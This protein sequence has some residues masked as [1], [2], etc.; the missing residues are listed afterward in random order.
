MT[1]SYLVAFVS[2]VLAL[3]DVSLLL[4][5]HVFDDWYYAHT[6]ERVRP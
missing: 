2:R 4:M 5:L 6:G 1:H 3:H